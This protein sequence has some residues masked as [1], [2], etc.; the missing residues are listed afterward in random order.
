[1]TDKFLIEVMDDAIGAA[2]IV[3][4]DAV[5]VNPSLMPVIGDTIF[6][7]LDGVPVVRILAIGDGRRVL[8]AASSAFPDIPA[9]ALIEGVV[10]EVRR[11][12]R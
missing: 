3:A 9:P 2:G 1:M 6:V 8:R 7:E 5:L 11:V 10:T 4:G 12:L